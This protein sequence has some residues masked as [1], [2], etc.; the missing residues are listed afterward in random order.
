MKVWNQV[1]IVGAGTMGSGIA[2]IAAQ[3]GCQVVLVDASEDALAR[4][5]NNL[6]KVFSRLVEKGRLTEVESDQIKG[7]IHRTTSIDAL[8]TAELVIEA[9]VED[10][11]VKT[12]L[13]Q[14]LEHIVG[15]NTVLA[16]NTSSLSVTA[17]A[18]GCQ[19]PE[20]VIGLH[21]F[22]PAPLMALVE[23]IPALQTQS[24]LAEQAMSAMV[25][26]GK[27]PALATDTPGFIVN[28]VARPFYSEALRILEEGIASV[29]DIDASMRAKGF[30]MGP[31]ELMDLIGHDVNYKVTSTVH[32]A[33]FGD[34][35]YRPSHTQ[36]QLVAAHWLGRKTGRGFYT[37]GESKEA[38][39]SGVAV[40][41]VSERIL[42]MLM[43]EA[44]NAV[45]W[46][47]GSAEAI[48]LAMQ[49][50]VN[51]PKGLLAWADEWGVQEVIN[52]LESLRQ[53]YG[54]ERYRVSPLLRDMARTK[55]TFFN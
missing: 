43:N 21:F 50:G 8:A 37:Y 36:R 33:F 51:Y 47:V 19:R 52:V 28:R 9:I 27:S 38:T 10:L 17:L 30:R 31:F 53:R 3:A 26:W 4:S 16:T 29:E 25:A 12:E 6:N 39:P 22:N 42:A 55:Q 40:E 34:T 23:V 2:Q 35:R 18:K 24:G 20:Q 48:D 7:R 1:G 5:E 54:E 46:Q 13:F 11:G 14:R 49:K 44:A 32:E 41:G 15:K 45:F